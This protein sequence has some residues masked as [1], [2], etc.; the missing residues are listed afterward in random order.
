MLYGCSTM[1]SERQTAR[2]SRNDA[3]EWSG[4]PVAM[5]QAG[6]RGVLATRWDMF[7]CPAG[8]RL[9]GDLVARARTA[10]DLAAALHDVQLEWL[11]R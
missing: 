11:R 2:R 3:A 7:D 8:A 5:L 4:L 10:P 1:G 6:A 9:A